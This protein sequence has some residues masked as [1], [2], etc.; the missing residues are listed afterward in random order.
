MLNA[1]KFKRLTKIFPFY[2]FSDEGR[3]VEIM[4]RVK[5]FNLKKQTKIA[6]YKFLDIGP[7]LQNMISSRVW[8]AENPELNICGK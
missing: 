8:S 4:F 1:N 5:N 2:F 6:S 3:F 7:L